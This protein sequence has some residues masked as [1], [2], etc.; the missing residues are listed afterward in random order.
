VTM[1]SFRNIQIVVWKMQIWCF[2]FYVLLVHLRFVDV[3][4]EMC[5]TIVEI[6]PNTSWFKVISTINLS[7]FHFCFLLNSNCLYIVFRRIF[8][9]NQLP[10]DITKQTNNYLNIQLHGFVRCT[11]VK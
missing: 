8:M 7:K 1:D 5:M 6:Y 4:L 9:Y 11:I 10:L 3:N 2:I